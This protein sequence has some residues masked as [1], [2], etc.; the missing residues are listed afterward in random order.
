[1]SRLTWVEGCLSD[2]RTPHRHGQDRPAGRRLRESIGVNPVCAMPGI[3]QVRPWSGWLPAFF[4]NPGGN[5]A[6]ACKG[7]TGD[8]DRDGAQRED[9]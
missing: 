4:K 9:L 2:C 7:H 3:K 6:G 1:M 5:P 8:Q